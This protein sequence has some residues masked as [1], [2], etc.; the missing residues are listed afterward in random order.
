MLASEYDFLAPTDE[1]IE[2]DKA[3]LP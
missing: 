3:H 1:K 2:S